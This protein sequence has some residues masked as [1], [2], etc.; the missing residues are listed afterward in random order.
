M[1]I[2]AGRLGERYGRL[3]SEVLRTSA[4]DFWL[5]VEVTDAWDSFQ[6]KKRKEAKKAETSA[7]TASA[8]EKEELAD[9][10][11]QRADER[12]ELRDQGGAPDL[13]DQL[14]A[15]EDKREAYPADER[16]QND[17]HAELEDDIDVE[18]GRR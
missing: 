1:A 16:P 11:A 12:D 6:E 10:Q 2:Q 5:N 3:P 8:K 4:S 17:Y 18:G 15:L 13:Q 7:G 9:R 14:A